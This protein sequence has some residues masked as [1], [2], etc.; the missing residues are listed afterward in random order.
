MRPPIA[1]LCSLLLLAGLTSATAS[2][3]PLSAQPPSAQPPSARTPSVQAA[4]SAKPAVAASTDWPT[5]H[6]NAARSGYS[7]STP[8][9]TGGLHVTA[10]IKLDGAVYASPIVAGG[11]TIVATE[12]D[13]IYA[14]NSANKK[15]WE[16]HL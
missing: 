4:A 1:V 6:G 12:N 3:R 11:L 14:F 15:V 9:Y 5:Y 7:A 2:A 10:R 13:T 8:R 16:R